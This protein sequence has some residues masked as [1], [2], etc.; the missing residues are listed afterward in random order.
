MDIKCDKYFENYLKSISDQQL[1]T[2]YRDIEYT[3][4]PILVIN[5]YQRRFKTI[6]RKGV[7]KKLRIQKAL[8]KI[9]RDHL[10]YLAKLSQP[11]LNKVLKEIIKDVKIKR[12]YFSRLATKKGSEVGILLK[13]QTQ[14]GLES[15]IHIAEKMKPSPKRNL[16]LIEI[17]GRLK[18]SGIIT[19]KEF[20]EKKKML[21]KKI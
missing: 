15:G 5:E 18:D 16:D 20:N 2:F 6:S 4:F 9:R 8:E 21:L 17:L 14:K 13:D 19:S 11:E 1:I 10:S 7:N 3:H 12:D